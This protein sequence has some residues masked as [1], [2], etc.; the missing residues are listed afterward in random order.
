MSMQDYEDA[1]ELVNELLRKTNGV[2]TF[3]GPRPKN[4]IE[5]AEAR[6]SVNFPETYRRFLLEYG[7]GGV[8]GV[9]FFGVVQENFEEAGY[10]DVVWFTLTARREWAFPIFL[11]PV[12]ELGDG[13]LYCLDFRKVE[14]NEARVV[15]FTP[16]YSAESQELDIV[17]KDFG[18]LFLSQIQIALK[19]NR[20]F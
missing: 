6:L 15:G 5:L 7:A 16:G 4:L 2:S 14:A 12:F 19:V 20:G 17:A 13:E 3:V 9:E 8:G 11:L 1:K 18:N 10:P